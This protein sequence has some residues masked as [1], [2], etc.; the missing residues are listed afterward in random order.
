MQASQDLIV[1]HLAV[2][3]ITYVGV[4]ENQGLQLWEGTQ[5]FANLVPFIRNAAED[6]QGGQV[7]ASWQYHL[8]SE[9]LPA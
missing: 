8:R 2:E 5:S 9:D 6:G 7:L 4:R 3:R 1:G